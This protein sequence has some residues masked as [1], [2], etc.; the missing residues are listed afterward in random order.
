MMQNYSF[1]NEFQE[2]FLFGKKRPG[3][4]KPKPSAA[5]SSVK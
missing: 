4:K 5:E 2:L 3:L 1:S